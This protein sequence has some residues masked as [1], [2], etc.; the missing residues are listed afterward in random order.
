MTITKPNKWLLY[1]SILAA[2]LLLAGAAVPVIAQEEPEVQEVVVTG[3]RGSLLQAL[4]NKRDSMTAVD[5]IMAEDIADFP[6]SNLAESLQRIPGVAITREAG[7]GREITV[8]GLDAKFT[9]VMLNNAPGH[10]LAAGSGGI[11]TSRAFDFN[12]FASELFNRI[13]VYKTQSAELDEGSLGATV[14]LHTARPF[15]YDPFTLALNGQATYN[16]LSEKNKPRGSGLL[17]FSNEDKTVGGLLSFAYTERFVN[18]IGSDTGRWAVDNFG[19]CSTCTDAAQEAQVDSAY[20]PRFPRYADKTD[21]QERTGLTGAFQFKPTDSTLITVDALYANIQATRREPFME[22]I[23]LARGSNGNGN[24][25]VSNFMID[26]NNNLI[27]ATIDGVDTRAEN[28][29]A[30]WESD[31]NQYSIKLEQDFGDRLHMTGLL[32]TSTSK[33]DNQETTLIYEHFS[34]DDSNRNRD[35]AELNDAVTYDLTSEFDPQVSYGFDTTNPANFELS[36]FRDRIFDGKS[37]NDSAKLDFAYDLSEILTLKAGVAY[38]DYT[39]NTAGARADRTFNSADRLDG[40]VDGVACDIGFAVDSSMGSVTSAGRQSFFMSDEGQFDRLRNSGCWPV[41]DRNSDIYEINEEV[42]AYY[43]QLDYDTEIAGHE[44]RGNIGVRQADTDMTS[45]APNE[46][47]GQVIETIV[48]NNYKDT[49]PSFNLAYNLTDD[50]LLR[51]AWAKVMTRP[52]LATLSPS[53]S[54]GIF[55]PCSVNIRNPFIDP[56]RAKNTDL[57]LEWYFGEQSLLSLAYFRKDIESFPSSERSFQTW[58]EIGLPDSLLG[59]QYDNV[60]NET[61]EVSRAING[62]GGKLDGW[63]LQYQQN[64]TFL[65][66]LLQNTGIIANL[67]LVDSSVDETGRP[68]EGQSDKTYN[69]TV[70]YED[71]KFSTRLAYSYR[72]GYTSSFNNDPN[73]ILYREDTANLDFSASY[74]VNDNFRVSLEGINLTDEPQL[75]Y[76]SPN[77]GGRLTTEQTTGTQWALGVAYKY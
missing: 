55:C 68:L 37:E 67:T 26:S 20:H 31:F 18:N 11:R 24:A 6:D 41:A 8:R 57:S 47:E 76:M 46:V 9:R 40:T 25:D 50:L 52:D 1:R 56:F 53:A 16:D 35:Y 48:T 4:D 43:L 33:M 12:V 21:D 38:N 71:D 65:P 2:N 15:D 19:S 39:F 58:A 32:S 28:F 69:L 29:V 36:E 23:S 13:D 59:A 66:G 42:T 51:A 61:F 34:E 27:A 30:N 75:D 17:S 77:V 10:S 5:S 7:E 54:V 63:E 73:Q 72:D 44:L 22:A 45:S 70:F 49:L 64:M 60:I 62:G 74:Q 3:F 14:D